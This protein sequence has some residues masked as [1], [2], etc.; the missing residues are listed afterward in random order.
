MKKLEDLLTEFGKQL[1]IDTRL[2]LKKKLVLRAKKTLAQSK[3]KDK[4]IKDV[5]SRL[6]ASVKNN[7]SYN[8]D[9]VKFTLTMNDYW[10]VVEN[11][12]RAAGVSK[13]GQSAILNWVETRGVAEKLRI[14][15]LENRKS[16]S[17]NPSK[18]KKMPFDK[19]KKL[20]MFLV[21]R[22][23]KKKR[24]EPTNFF[25]EVITDGRI[26]ELKTK[27]SELLKTEIIIEI[28]K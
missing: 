9:G 7:I 22:K 25:N 1:V 27:I 20:A 24:L 16:K 3:I 28:R 2:N 10:L 4:T 6:D 21:A 5:T 17:K 26:D 19:A 23:L 13:D 11:G 14:S 18:L 12:R 15:D 8:S